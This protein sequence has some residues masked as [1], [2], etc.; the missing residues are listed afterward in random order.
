[1]ATRHLHVVHLLIRQNRPDGRVGFLVYPHEHWKAPDGQPYLSLPAKKTVTDPLAEFIQGTSLD[2]YID[3][4]AVEEWKIP[5]GA[6][7]VDQEFAAAEW[8][9]PSAG[10]RDNQYRPVPTKYT[11][12]PVEIWVA[13]EH[14]EP[15][16]E[17]LQGRW[18]TPEE[19]LAE[20]W[21]SPTARGVFEEL[22]R[23][24]EQFHAH[25]PKPEEKRDT[26]EAEALRRLLGPVSDRPGMDALA[27][28]WLSHNLRGVRHLDKSTLDEILDVGDRAFNLRVADPYLR[29]QMQGLG[30]TWSFFTHKD[31]QDCHVHGAP[32]VE[33]YGI[34]EGRMEIWWK[35]Y[36]ERGTS[37]WNHRV[38]E[39]GDWLEVDSLQ[40]HIVHWLG[41]GKGVVFKAGPG[42]L[43]E[44]GKRGVKGK[45]PCTDCPCM[46]PEQV[47]ELEGHKS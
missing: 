13:L 14:R 3:A 1:V 2:A 18:L 35:P 9:L 16:R 33:I 42:P 5:S 24:H 28:E 10:Q 17:R 22:K 27:R 44:V 19:A 45:T 37:A 8:T 30:F 7:N 39:P 32:V 23:R 38:L 21:L 25:P 6:Y 20:S 31:K 12:Y 34:L 4:I 36:Y 11:V 40:C 43:A 29:Y 46:K 41:E 47:R 26:L 15:L